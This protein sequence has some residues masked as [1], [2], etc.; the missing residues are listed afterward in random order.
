MMSGYPD[1]RNPRHVRA[2]MDNVYARYVHGQDLFPRVRTLS[3][4]HFP[5]RSRQIARALFK[6]WEIIDEDRLFFDQSLEDA[7]TFIGE[8]QEQRLGVV[9]TTVG[10]NAVN[11][12]FVQNAGDGTPL[13]VL[14]G[15]Q[16][17]ES[18]AKYMEE[19]PHLMADGRVV[20]FANGQLQPEPQP[21]A[22]IYRRSNA[23][24]VF[25]AGAEKAA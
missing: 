24:S 15:T 18:F 11:F 2:L 4:D 23:A 6:A 10:R 1:T 17:R 22:V 13:T 19:N 8:V 16:D 5:P 12:A 7:V 3:P 20:S 21:E 9:T 14:H 25:I